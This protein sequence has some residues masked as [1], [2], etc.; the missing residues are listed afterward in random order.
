MSIFV[1][2]RFAVRDGH[3]ADFELIVVAY[4]ETIRVA[5]PDAR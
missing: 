3:Q 1:R 5:P 4:E 2:A